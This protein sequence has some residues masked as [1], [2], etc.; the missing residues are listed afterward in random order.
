[1]SQQTPQPTEIKRLGK[2]G[3]RITW[4]NGHAGEYTVPYL[5]RKCGCANC[6]HELTGKVLLDPKSVAEDLTMEGVELVGA[7]AIRIH[8]SDSHETGIYPFAYLWGI[9]P[10]GQHEQPG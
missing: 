6:V 5:R 2:A 7:Y 10:C 8:F 1:M 4:D 3:L 9:C